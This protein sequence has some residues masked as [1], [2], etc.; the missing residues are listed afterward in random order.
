MINTTGRR[1]RRRK[2]LLDDLKEKRGYWKLKQE[3]LDRFLW[4]TCS[5]SCY[6]PVLQ[7][8]QQNE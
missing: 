4:R 3:A 2:K 5:G 6:G 1:G 8:S 7:D